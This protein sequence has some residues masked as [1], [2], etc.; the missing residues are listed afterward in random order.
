MFKLLKTLLSGGATIGIDLGTTNTVVAVLQSDGEVKVIETAEGRKL[1]PSVVAFQKDGTVVVGDAAA[2]QAA[3]NPKTIY[4]VKRLMGKDFDDVKAFGFTVPYIVRPSYDKIKACVEIDGKPVDPEQ[5]SAEILKKCKEMAEN[6]LQK[7]VI[8]AVITV[9]AYFN[10]R[11]RQ[12]TKASAAIAGLKVD[13]IINEPTAAA[14]AYG[15][16]LK[17]KIE[18][19]KT[20]AVYDLGGGTFD[21]SIL[22][23]AESEFEVLSTSGNN[24]LGGDDFDNIILQKVLSQFYKDNSVDLTK[25]PESLQRV[26]EACTRAKIELSSMAETEVA[27]PFISQGPAGPLHVNCKIS[28]KEFED[29]IAAMVKGSIANVAEALSSAS[30]KI[31]DIDEVIMVGG[32]S[33]IP[34]VQKA[35][36]DFFKREPMKHDGIDDLVAIGAAVFSGIVTGKI[37]DVD[38]IDITSLS[39]GTATIGDVLSVIIPKGSKTPIEVKGDFT[40]VTDNQKQA[41]VQ[42]L[43]GEE[44]KASLNHKLGEVVVDDIEPQPKGVPRIFITYRIDGNGV[45][46]VAAVDSKG[47]EQNVTVKSPK[48]ESTEIKRIQKELE[49]KPEEKRLLSEAREV[50][51]TE[52]KKLEIEAKDAETKEEKATLF[53]K[54]EE[55]EK[56][57]MEELKPKQLIAASNEIRRVLDDINDET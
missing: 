1:L 35:V 21:V 22:K 3:I 6:Y 8:S 16:F 12:A 24:F 2:R 27:I 4:S 45:F 19:A 47:V 44:K 49:L 39:L 7:S 20:I 54:V 11:Q 15:Y 5:I 26:K 30:L 46:S 13:R 28:R 41:L 23:V 31:T 50:L 9:P 18:T 40:T 55:A 32:S 57:I 25:I 51:S 37:E 42:V 29:M 56:I 17:D 38:V 33:R 34:A 14:I 52:L 43:E 48:L 53:V 36:K 10:D